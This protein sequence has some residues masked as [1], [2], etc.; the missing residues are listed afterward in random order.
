MGRKRY[1]PEQIIRKEV[2]QQLED[3][4]FGVWDIAYDLKRDID[5]VKRQAR[6]SGDHELFLK[7]SLAYIDYAQKLGIVF[8]K[9][10]TL[11]VQHSIYTEEEQKI[12][13]S[14]YRRIELGLPIPGETGTEGDVIEL[15]PEQSND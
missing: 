11:E 4:G 8:K 6:N 1:T 12:L 10:Q 3:N 14:H 15:V 5:F 9:P 13:I 2:K 7:A